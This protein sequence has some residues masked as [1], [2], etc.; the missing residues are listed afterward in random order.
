[1]GQRFGSNASWEDYGNGTPQGWDMPA[2]DNR[3][4]G[5]GRPPSNRPAFRGDSRP[6]SESESGWY[7]SQQP[8]IT[9]QRRN[10]P[11]GW[12][13]S[14]GEYDNYHRTGPSSNRSRTTSNSYAEEYEASGIYYSGDNNE[15]RYKGR[16]PGKPLDEK[17]YEYE[18]PEDYDRQK[19]STYDCLQIYSAF[20]VPGL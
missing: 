16:A 7:S 12:N 4:T 20:L 5:M 1:M 13:Y 19:V 14:L 17:H 2:Q 3:V 11:N 9:H 6:N 15:R 8:P 18:Y 10:D